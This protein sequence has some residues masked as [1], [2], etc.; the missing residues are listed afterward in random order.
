MPLLHGITDAVIKDG[1]S[2]RD[3]R[4]NQNAIT[5]SGTK[6]QDGSYI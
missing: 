5:A 4:R 1:R 3:D 2:R 6:A